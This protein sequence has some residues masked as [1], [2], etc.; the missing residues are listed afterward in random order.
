MFEPALKNTA[1]GGGYFSW[2]IWSCLIQKPAMKLLRILDIRHGKSCNSETSLGKKKTVLTI[3]V[4]YL[5]IYRTNHTIIKPPARK[6][7]VT[8]RG[9]V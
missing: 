7:K 8:S 4:K 5:S 9:K 1:A 6:I 2:T 3:S